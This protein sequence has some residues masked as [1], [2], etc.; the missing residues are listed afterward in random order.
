MALDLKIC[1]SSEA[2]QE[3]QRYERSDLSNTNIHKNILQGDHANKIEE[4]TFPCDIYV[5]NRIIGKR[6]RG[7]NKY[8]NIYV[9]VIIKG[10]KDK[11]EFDRCINEFEE[12]NNAYLSYN[13]SIINDFV[14]DDRV[15]QIFESN[16]QQIRSFFSFKSEIFM[17]SI[18]PDDSSRLFSVYFKL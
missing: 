10:L 7:D 2:Y 11:R 13:N 1:V 14:D 5:L 16:C 17:S 8:H 9:S 3:L 6:L 15:E 18:D 4:L 12:F